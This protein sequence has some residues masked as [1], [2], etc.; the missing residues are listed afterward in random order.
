MRIGKRPRVL[1][2]SPW[3]RTPGSTG[4]LVVDEE[5][6]RWARWYKTIRGGFDLALFNIDTTSLLCAC[7]WKKASR[8]KC[9]IV[10]V[11]TILNRPTGLIG[12]AKVHLFQWLFQEVDLFL[13]YCRDTVD[14][15]GL[16]GIRPEHVEY[17][18]FKVNALDRVLE[19]ATY[20]DGWFLSCGRSYRD[21][22][23]LCEAFDG[24]P[25]KCMILAPRRSTGAH[26]TFL[27]AARLPA[28]VE[29]IA[30][31]GTADSWNRWISRCTALVV[32]L[33][34]NTLSPAG[35]GTYLVGMALGK[36]VIVT[37]GVGTRGILDA[38]TAVIVRAEDAYGLRD[39]VIR[40]ATDKAFRERVASAGKRYAV[41]L[42]GEDRLAKD[43]A[44]IVR[45]MLDQRA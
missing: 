11:D 44:V 38:E 30:D 12:H 21:Y 33:I 13:F 23:L 37:E 2:N 35:I 14:L 16:Y 43:I 20:D 19:L 27:D 7:L 18:P 9:T 8:S 25:Y 3:L 41:S 29:L 4:E 40:V 1:T 26:G 6:R 5:H 42:G 24:L 15:R 39:A 10:A 31:D 32:P 45:R 34:P 28:N 17:V 36:C 22:D